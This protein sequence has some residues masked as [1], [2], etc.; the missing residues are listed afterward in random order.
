MRIFRRYNAQHKTN[1]HEG[2]EY[3]AF[4]DREVRPP[5]ES[6][7]E[8]PRGRKEHSGA[9]APKRLPRRIRIARVK[10]SR[11]CRVMAAGSNLGGTA[12]SYLCSRPEQKL[13][14]IFYLVQNPGRQQVMAAQG[15]RGKDV[16]SR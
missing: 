4:P 8:E 13:L 1:G 12:G 9:G 3:P 2:D 7:T 11:G 10:G 16:R 14:G 6:C 5:A 15:L